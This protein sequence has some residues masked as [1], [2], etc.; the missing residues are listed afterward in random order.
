MVSRTDFRYHKPSIIDRIFLLRKRVVTSFALKAGVAVFVCD[1]PKPSA[2]LKFSYPGNVQ[3]HE[4]GEQDFRLFSDALE[5][6]AGI[7][8]DNNKGSTS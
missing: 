5:Y 3:Y 6:A 2:I 1:R 4:I 7:L 8:S